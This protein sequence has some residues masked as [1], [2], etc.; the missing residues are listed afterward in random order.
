MD[1]TILF[2]EQQRFTQWWL[3]V[4]LVPVVVLEAIMLYREKLPWYEWWPLLIS[5]GVFALIL[6]IRMR[7]VIT[8]EAITVYYFPLLQKP[9]VF[10]W[11]ALDKVYVREYSPLSE[12]GGWGIKGWGSKYG[13][14]Y[15]VKG[16]KGLQL[17]LKDGKKVLIGTQ[18]PIAIE[19]VLQ[20]HFKQ[21]IKA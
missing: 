3:Y 20:N 12:Y 1:G 16:N 6:L 8:D 9:K 14:A 18:E 4:S 2:Q 19:E 21:Y 15:N 13:R 7:T 10:L 17:E 5:I 11:T